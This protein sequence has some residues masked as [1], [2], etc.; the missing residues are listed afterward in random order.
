MACTVCGATTEVLTTCLRCTVARL[1]K[2]A[3]RRPA[4][5]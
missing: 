5:A 1:E 3:E 2:E 4:P